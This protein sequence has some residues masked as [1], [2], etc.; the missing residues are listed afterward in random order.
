[1]GNLILVPR[2][3]GCTTGTLQVP[4]ALKC[5]FH[6]QAVSFVKGG[7]KGFLHNLQK[8]A[9]FAVPVLLIL[10]ASLSFCLPTRVSA[11]GG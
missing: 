9:T 5:D 2:D 4:G 6:F 8:F 1:M 3:G 11:F 10:R 7:G